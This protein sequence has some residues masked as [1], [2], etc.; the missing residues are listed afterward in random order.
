MEPLAKEVFGVTA[1]GFHRIVY[2][3]WGQGEPTVV[4]AHGLTRNGRDFDVLAQALGAAGR[5]VVCPDIVGRGRSG[6]LANP[7]SYNYGQYIADMAVLLGRL[8]A[9]P[10]DWVG[11]S[12]GGLIG[13]IIA[14]AAGSPIRRLVLNDVG[15]FVAHEALERI[16]GYVGLDPAF[17]DLAALEAYLREIYR[18]FGPL[19]DAQ[20][21][22][23]SRH[24]WRQKPDGQLGLAFDPGIAAAFKAAPISDLDLWAL[25][26]RI[27]CPVLVLRGGDSDLLSAD[28][29]ARMAEKAQLVTLPGIGHAPGLMALDQ[30]AAISRFLSDGA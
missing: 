23:L 22:H 14:A 3:E 30:I 4:C 8:D 21:Q 13:L 18:P 10:V 17:T 26:E 7:Q 11:T 27:D 12:M 20:W 2:T 24:S 16:A 9:A 1:A 19:S 15:P 6:W 29:A 5:R 28:T 25:W